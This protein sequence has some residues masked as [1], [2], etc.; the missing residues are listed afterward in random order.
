MMLVVMY[1]PTGILCDVS[2][3]VSGDTAGDVI[4]DITSNASGDVTSGE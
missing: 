3:D 1:R 4:S 2:G